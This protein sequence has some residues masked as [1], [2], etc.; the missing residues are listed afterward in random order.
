MPDVELMRTILI[1]ALAVVSSASGAA[2]QTPSTRPATSVVN[3]VISYRR[4]FLA[5]T[6]R[7]DACSVYDWTARQPQFPTG[8]ANAERVLLGVAGE[9]CAHGRVSPAAQAVRHVVLVDSATVSG[10][11]AVVLLTVR[12]GEYTHHETFTL[13]GHNGGATWGVSDVR[14][15]GSIQ[16]SPAPQRRTSTP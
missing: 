4:S 7:F 5:D 3:A 1:L 8:T 6:T 14:L 13:V 10:S 16:S 15:W 12:H 11:R 2:A 9:A